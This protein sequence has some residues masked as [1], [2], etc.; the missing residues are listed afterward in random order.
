MAEPANK[1]TMLVTEELLNNVEQ[2]EYRSGFSSI[3]LMQIPQGIVMEGVVFKPLNPLYETFNEKVHHLISG[4]LMQY[5]Q[6]LQ[7][8][9]VKGIREGIRKR[10]I[11]IGPQV[12]KL[13]HLKIGFFIFI[14]FLVLSI[15]VFLIEMSKVFLP[16]CINMLTARSIVKGFFSNYIV[17]S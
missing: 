3:S 16:Y 4:G 13:E 2:T 1:G 17:L 12:L 6:N 15:L 8:R 11:S 14:I 10:D 7:K 5:F 9:S